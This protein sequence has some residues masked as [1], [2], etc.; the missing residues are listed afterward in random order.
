MLFSRRLAQIYYPPYSSPISLSDRLIRCAMVKVKII[1]YS[2]CSFPYIPLCN[3]R[4]QAVQFLRVLQ[5]KNLILPNCR[6]M[7][8]NNADRLCFTRRKTHAVHG[9]LGYKLELTMFFFC[10]FFFWQG[11]RRQVMSPP[12][13]CTPTSAGPKTLTIWKPPEYRWKVPSSSPDMVSGRVRA[14]SCDYESPLGPFS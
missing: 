3:V 10:F 13:S 9:Y 5:G 7:R 4:L 2:F 14:I 12:S 8:Q 11:T 6:H 1:F